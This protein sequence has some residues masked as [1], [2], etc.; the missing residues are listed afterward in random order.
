M[1]AYPVELPEVPG[2]IRAMLVLGTRPEVI[3]LAP[4]A[5]AMAASR[6]FEP[7]VV[8]TGQHR[9]MLHQ[10]LELLQVPAKAGLDVMR[11]R[12]QLS[13]LTARLAEGLGEVIRNDR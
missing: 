7:V 11:E 12:Q 1:S 3:K 9:E 4:V 6:L 8:T 13:E 5:R 2:T 10:M